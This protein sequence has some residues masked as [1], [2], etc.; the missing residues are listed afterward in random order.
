MPQWSPLV[1]SGMT[2]YMQAHGDRVAWSQWRPLVKSGM[3]TPARVDRLRVVLMPQWSPL[4]K[5]GMTARYHEPD[6]PARLLRA[7]AMEPAREE[8]DD[9]TSYGQAIDMA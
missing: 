5:S 6:S 3:T 9:T 7:A 4:V 2:P 8:R 1:K